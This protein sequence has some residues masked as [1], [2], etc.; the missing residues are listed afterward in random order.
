MTMLPFLCLSFS[1]P[2]PDEMPQNKEVKKFIQ[3]PYDESACKDDID[4]GESAMG[5]RAGFFCDSWPFYSGGFAECC[6]ENWMFYTCGHSVYDAATESVFCDFWYE[7]QRA[8]TNRL[9]ICDCKMN[10]G[11]YCESWICATTYG[12]DLTHQNDTKNMQ[13]LEEILMPDNAIEIR[14][15]DQCGYFEGESTEGRAIGRWCYQYNDFTACFCSKGDDNTCLQW[16]CHRYLNNAINQISAENDGETAMMLSNGTVNVMALSTKVTDEQYQCQEKHSVIAPG[17]ESTHCT[18]W[19]GDITN[20][21]ADSFVVV[22][23][24]APTP[25]NDMVGDDWTFDRDLMLINVSADDLR[26]SY[27]YKWEC[28]GVGMDNRDNGQFMNFYLSTIIWSVGVGLGLLTL[29]FCWM[30][31]KYITLSSFFCVQGWFV[32]I[33]GSIA[34]VHGG[35]A[36]LTIYVMLQTLILFYVCYLKCKNRGKVPYGSLAQKY[37]FDPMEES[38]SRRSDDDHL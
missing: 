34:A 11:V 16:Q 14:G 17:L 19:T 3:C 35:V 12:Y 21:G 33:F 20:Y 10:N 4:C 31:Y 13:F 25:W 15:V 28:H 38:V 37:D 26:R 5:R 1:A 27:P 8:D 32:F 30:Q 6:D 18:E 7:T 2:T 23:C 36:S 22:K 29:I 9:D 24:E